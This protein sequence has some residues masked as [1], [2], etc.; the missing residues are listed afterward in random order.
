MIRQFL[1]L[2]CLLNIPFAQ[3]FDFPQQTL[4]GFECQQECS[5]SST[6]LLSH[7]WLIE[8][9]ELKHRPALKRISRSYQ[10]LIPIS[11]LCQ[12]IDMHTTA[13]N[14]VI[15]VSLPPSKHPTL[16]LETAQGKSLSLA[17][18][19]SLLSEDKRFHPDIN[20]HPVTFQLKSELGS[21]RFKLKSKNY[22][23]DNELLKIDVFDKFSALYLSIETDKTDY[24][25]GE[26]IKAKLHIENSFPYGIDDIK[27]RLVS[28]QGQSYPL[29]VDQV[30]RRQY[31]ARG[32]L[33]AEEHNPGGIWYV[34]AEITAVND[35]EL[36]I[37]SVRTAFN[38]V[39]PTARLIRLKAIDDNQ[40]QFSIETSNSGRYALNTVLYHED[41]FGVLHPLRMYQTANWLPKGLSDLRI[42]LDKD[43][44]KSYDKE[45]LYL[46]Y[47]H[48]LDYEQLKTV[49]H[50]D[51]PIR[52]FT[53]E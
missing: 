9:K 14:A 43:S 7:D 40:Y 25:Y 34:E 41:A 6:K 22:C 1:A 4:H 29:A 13:A 20:L 47:S 52:L 3:A 46:G 33:H 23:Q 39:M 28:S 16:W 10:Q 24:Y 51:E 37:R 38:Y 11:K 42:T 26:T 8:D 30:S 17:Q 2:L 53:L 21:G 32:K 12:G 15:R 49:Y 44:L 50:F 48:L 45:K 19:T 31:V 35:E 18:A 36:F 27:V 5:E